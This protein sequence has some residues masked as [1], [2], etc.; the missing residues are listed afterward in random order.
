MQI[1][2]VDDDPITV[3]LLENVVTQLGH[4]AIAARNGREAL[5]LMRTDACRLV[6][7]DW[8][9]P[10]MD[11]IELC[12]RIRQRY[13]GSYVYIIL[14]T[15]R[16]GSQNIIDGLNAGADEFLS[17]PFDTDELAVRIRAGERILSLESRDVT[18]FALAKLAESRDQETGAHVDRVREYS[19]VV[20]EHLA[21]QPK[22]HDQVDG[23]FVQLIYMTSPLH[24]I[25]KVGIP[26]KILLK[27][28]PLTVDEFE[29]MQ[30]H[31]VAGA[32]TLDSA[33]YAHPEAKFL[34]MARDIA[35]SHHEWFDGSGYPDGLAGSAI[36][37]SG[38]IVGLIDVYD[39]LTTKHVYKPAFSHEVASQIII[40]SSGT[41]FDPDMVQAFL[42]N[43]DRFVE[44]FERFA[45]REEKE[46]RVLSRLQNELSLSC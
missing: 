44:I 3:D 29:I 31:T 33:I 32:M 14:L 1:L 4:S 46:A 42:A 23:D 26:D 5:E 10:Q 22:F 30:Q 11:G 24:D 6:I 36:P 16:S 34:C 38:R 28:G 40:E 7:T 20:A 19:R 12:R 8:E 21:R 41:Q 25:G 17:K 15:A 39:A 43:E 35:R 18:I 37:L 2:I 27:A 13:S 9:M 45:S